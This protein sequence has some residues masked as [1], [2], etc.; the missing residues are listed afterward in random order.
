M[1]DKKPK[2]SFQESAE[3]L[4]VMRYF[5]HPADKL[6]GKKAG[7]RL[8]KMN[9]APVPLSVASA[10][11][12]KEELKDYFEQ[13]ELELVDSVLIERIRLY[14]KCF[15]EDRKIR[16]KISPELAKQ[17]ALEYAALAG[18]TPDQLRNLLK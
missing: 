16:D 10:A 15:F 13:A 9:R 12:T 17:K 5:Y 6:S 4:N 1:E 7:S 3:G 2:F 18:L 14:A 11:Q 8:M